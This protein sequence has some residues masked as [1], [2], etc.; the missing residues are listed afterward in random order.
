MIKFDPK[1]IQ[2]T[3]AYTTTPC[4]V[5]ADHILAIFWAQ[6]D[7]TELKLSSGQVCAVKESPNDVYSLCI[8][9]DYGI[10]APPQP[11]T[12]DVGK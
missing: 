2:L 11:Q 8:V 5:R 10:K 4:Y 6:K 12:N 9:T 1:M 7:R 3:C